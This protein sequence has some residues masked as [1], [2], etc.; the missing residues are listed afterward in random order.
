MSD[1][2]EAASR[3]G[4]GRKP[5][6]QRADRRPSRRAAPGPAEEPTRGRLGH[7]AADRPRA[8]QVVARPSIRGVVRT[9]AARAR[10]VASGERAARQA[11]GT[12]PGASTQE[13]RP[14]QG[15]SPRASQCGLWESSG[16]CGRL[17]ERSAGV[18]GLACRAACP[19]R[20]FPMRAP[21]SR[22]HPSSSRRER[23]RGHSSISRGVA[24]RPS[25]TMSARTSV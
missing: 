13:G 11:G 12:A 3:A 14:G 5:A 16:W 4:C 6:V 21:V 8:T 18:R 15:A 17:T 24:P 10:A 23:A 25:R 20:A 7:K 9:L 1:R 22:P 19:S 2:R